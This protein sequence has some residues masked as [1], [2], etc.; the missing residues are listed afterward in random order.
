MR[1]FPIIGQGRDLNKMRDFTLKATILLRGFGGHDPRGF[2]LQDLAV[3]D[4]DQHFCPSG[5]R[6]GN[7]AKRSSTQLQMAIR[8]S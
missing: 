7:S 4:Y 5:V 2:G 8:Q 1:R 6:N 3:N